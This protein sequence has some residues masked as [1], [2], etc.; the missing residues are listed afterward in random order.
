MANCASAIMKLFMILFQEFTWKVGQGIP[1]TQSCWEPLS[2][3]LACKHQAGNG[4]GTCFFLSSFSTCIYKTRTREVK[5]FSLPIV[6]QH[7][8]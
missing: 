5:T 8:Q 6:P 4:L 7:V 3:S 2:C 1:G